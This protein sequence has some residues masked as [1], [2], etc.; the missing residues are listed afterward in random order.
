MED[1]M[2]RRSVRFGVAAARPSPRRPADRPAFVRTEMAKTE[3]VKAAN[4]K[5]ESLRRGNLSVLGGL[6]SA[7][8][9]YHVLYI[10]PMSY[11]GCSARI[12][13][14]DFLLAGQ[15]PPSRP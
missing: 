3:V 2:N 1:V 7:T 4:I 10:F 5:I 13:A 9:R 14:D 8:A 12:Q 11:G 6:K 15:A